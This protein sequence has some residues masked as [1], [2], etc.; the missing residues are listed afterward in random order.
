MN[1]RLLKTFFYGSYINF[2]VLAEAGITRREYEIGRVSGFELRISSL[3]NLIP[4]T[5][6]TAY[7]IITELD[8]DELDQLYMEH[9]RKKL[10]G[11]YLPE[12]VLVTLEN[13]SCVPALCYVAP[14]LDNSSP[15][16]GYVE[17]I[18][19]PANEYGFPSWYLAHI[20]S[21]AK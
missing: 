20:E 15:K 4:K 17:R 16:P 8:H 21:F 12:A 18:L 10:G 19:Q 3:A 9:S 11:V 2:K 7:G 5:N 13:G 6:G 1:K 14:H